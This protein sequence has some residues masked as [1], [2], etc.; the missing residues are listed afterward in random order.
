MKKN[1]F[2]YFILMLILW[3]VHQD[4]ILPLFL[5]YGM[6][7]LFVKGLL[8][9]KELLL[10]SAIIYLI[11]NYFKYKKN[12]S[13]L[14][15]IPI[16]YIGLTLIYF[17][18]GVGGWYVKCAAVR[19]L[20]LPVLLFLVGCGVKLTQNNIKTLIYFLIVVGIY[21]SC[22]GYIERFLFSLEF[23]SKNIEIG[24]YIS[25]IKGVSGFVTDGVHGNIFSNF[26]R[27][28]V[29]PFGNP[30]SFAYF[31]VIPTV[32]MFALFHEKTNNSKLWISLGLVIL[33]SAIVFSITRAVILCLGISL[34][35]YLLFSKEW[36]TLGHL[37]GVTSI[38]L[39]IGFNH[40]FGIFVNSIYLEETSAVSHFKDFMM[41]LQYIMANPLGRGVGM[42]GA[43]AI[44]LSKDVIGPG[45]VSYFVI[46]FQIGVVGLV[47]FLLFW[48]LPNIK[49][50]KVSSKKEHF[51]ENILFVSITIAS[52]CYFLTGWFSEQ[53]FTFTSVAHYW[54][55][56]GIATRLV[57]DKSK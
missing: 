14:V 45:E 46:V 32:M 42:A 25:Q 20:S 54:I 4:I 26:G 56:L 49:I 23:W 8:L 24:S 5:K 43:W 35:L 36:K 16:L 50:W 21:I 1:T 3:I 7:P 29:G 39:L 34:F 51:Y 27:R 10:I 12:R 57:E 38:I 19:S 52:L 40:W 13:L 44:S 37:L 55:L 9:S 15:F 11:F 53:I 2:F 18:V 22:F 28:M 41:G 17:W 33:L 48:F 6:D 30:L 31:L 47:L